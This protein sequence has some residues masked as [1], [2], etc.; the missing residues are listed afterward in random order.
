VLTQIFK[1]FEDANSKSHKFADIPPEMFDSGIHRQTFGD[2]KCLP[3]E[4]PSSFLISSIY[5]QANAWIRGIIQILEDFRFI[6]HWFA[7]NN[8][9]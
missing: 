8:I 6:A 4:T 5:D 1:P 2:S 3:R 7:G 9:P